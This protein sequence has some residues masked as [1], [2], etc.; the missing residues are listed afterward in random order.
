ME[1]NRP[2][3]GFMNRRAGDEAVRS[4]VALVPSRVAPFL[5]ALLLLACDG[6]NSP[7]PSVV[8]VSQEEFLGKPPGSYL[9]LDVRSDAEFAAGHLEGA[10]HV[11][12]DQLEAR[13]SSLREHEGEPVLVYCKSGRRAA[14]AA[15]TLAEAGFTKLRHLQGDYDG[16]VAAG[17]PVVTDGP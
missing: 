4:F 14:L 5:F 9:I 13:L 17:R 8:D 11:P 1:T 15:E 7:P 16:W 12:H 3:R 6:A 2:K 10:L